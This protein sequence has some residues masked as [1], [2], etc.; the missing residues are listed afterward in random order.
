[1][2]VEDIEYYSVPRGNTFL[3]YNSTKEINFIKHILTVREKQNVQL[4]SCYSFEINFGVEK[5]RQLFLKTCFIV[6]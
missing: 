5:N 1:M 2:S 3:L 4:L 6:L